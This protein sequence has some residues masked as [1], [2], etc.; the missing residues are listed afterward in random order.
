MNLPKLSF[1]ITAALAATALLS[2]AACGDDQA[3]QDIESGPL[4]QSGTTIMSPN[5]K[6]DAVEFPQSFEEFLDY[7]YCESDGRICVV[8]GDTP[9]RGGWAGLRE[10]Y[11]T[12]VNPQGQ[13]LS[14]NRGSRGDDLWYGDQRFDLSFCV[15]DEFGERKQEVVDAMVGAAEDW[16]EIADV[17]FPYRDDQDHRCHIENRQVLFPVTPSEPNSPYLA[18]AF[19]PAFEEHERDVVVNLPEY[20][21]ARQNSRMENLSLR[22]IMRH[23]LGHV[24]GFRHE[25][26]RD[27]AGLYYCF[28]DHNFRPGTA[29]DSESVMHYPQCGG[30]NDWTLPLSETDEIGAAYFYPPEGVEVLGRCDDEIDEEGLVDESC[31]A[32]TGQIVN[33][34]SQ[35]GDEEVLKDWMALD[36]TLAEAIAA[37]RSSRP[38]DDLDDLRERTEITDDEIRHIYDYLFVWGRCP[39]QEVDEEGWVMPSCFPV[40]NKILELANEAPFVILDEEVGLDRRAVENIVAAREQRSIDTYDALIALGYVKRA[41][42]YAMYDYLYEPG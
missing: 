8:D 3:E 17:R 5:G 42:L 39:D 21:A 24:L 37:E 23:E 14:V 9:I 40:V 2:I 11:D 29:Y 30:D 36:E 32:V 27:E 4:P 33:W 20:D 7:V 22:G 38:F 16:E 25:H 26:T 28:E 41:A 15:S 34:L 1:K 35:F 12:H 13:A 19:F 18:R 6:G 10:F 31:Q